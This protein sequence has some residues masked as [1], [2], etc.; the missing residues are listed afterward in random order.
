MDLRIRRI[1]V[2]LADEAGT[3][4]TQEISPGELWNCAP[5]V[6]A[7]RSRGEEAKKPKEAK[8]PSKRAK[9]AKTREKAEAKKPKE[10]KPR[11]NLTKDEDRKQVF[12]RILAAV[13]EKPLK[14]TEIADRLDLDRMQVAA[15]LSQMVDDGKLLVSGKG[16][17]AR[18][19]LPGTSSAAEPTPVPEAAVTPEEVAPPKV[20]LRWKKR[21]AGSRETYIAPFEDGFF[22][23]LKL[24]GDGDALFYERGPLLWEY[25]CG[26]REFLKGIAQQL[27]EAGLPTPEQYRAAGGDVKACSAPR[28]LRLGNVELAWRDTVEG[29]K[30]VC[31][32]ATGDGEMRLVESDNGSFMLV[33]QREGDANFDSFGIGERADLEARALD[34]LAQ[35]RAAEGESPAN[36][37][38]VPEPEPEAEP[39]AESP[40][41][42]PAAEAPAAIEETEAVSPEMDAKIMNA[43]R[44]VLKD[45]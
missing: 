2:E 10:R 40:T 3:V 28:R 32:A 1:V 38:S 21:M 44:D 17:R 15:A 12:E 6:V 27:A 7:S 37:E 24:R 18:Y 26:E 16:V 29:G 33:F 39:T 30:Q 36:P 31:V 45:L 20:R 5:G 11:V 34:V 14:A 42:S 25:G 22:Q 13:G 41:E 43:L 23:V 35:V 8:R 9:E 19:R 4:R